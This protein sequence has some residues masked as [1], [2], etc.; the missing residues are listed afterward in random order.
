[1]AACVALPCS[2]MA[3]DRKKDIRRAIF[4][5]SSR[6][7]LHYLILMKSGARRGRFYDF[8]LLDSPTVHSCASNL[9]LI[10]VFGP[11]PNHRP[12]LF[13]DIRIDF[14]QTWIKSVS[15]TSFAARNPIAFIRFR[16]E[17]ISLMPLAA[18]SFEAPLSV[19]DRLAGF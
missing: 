16:I 15:T 7:R 3:A 5:G 18:K 9:T 1:M 6:M 11:A 8:G 12:I 19:I 4:I 13:S 10:L 2:S 14:N 17:I